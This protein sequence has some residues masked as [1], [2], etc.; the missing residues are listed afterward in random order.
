M[1]KILS[2]FFVLF[3]CAVFADDITPNHTVHVPM[4]D[5]KTLSMDIYLPHEGAENLPCILLRS[6]AGRSA[7]TAKAYAPLA[8]LGYAVAIQDT[9]SA[10]DPE[11]KTLPYVSDSWCRDNDGQ[12]TIAWLSKNPITNGKIGTMGFSAMGITQLLLAPSAPSSLKC[13]FIGTAPASL[14]HYAIFPSGVLLKNQVEG[15]LGYYAR[16]SGVCTFVSNQLFN[17][18]FWEDYDTRLGVDEVKVPAI[19]QGGWYDTFLQ[20]TIE[21]FVTRQESGGEGGRGTQ[22]LLI[23]PWMHFWPMTVKL[24]DFEVPMLGR[25]VPYEISPQRWFDFH[26]K[27]IDNGIGKI[28]AVVYYVM[29]PFDGSESSGNLWRS[30]DKWP[31]PAENISFY[32]GDEGALIEKFNS[33]KE[34]EKVYI[35][36]PSNPIPTI[37]GLNLFLEAGP[38]DQQPIESRSDV[39][40]FTTPVLNEDVEITGRLAAKLFLKSESRDAHVIVKLC[41]VYPDGRSILIAEGVHR[42]GLLPYI[43]GEDITKSEG[44]HEVDVDMWSTAIV[45]AKGHR[46]RISISGSNYPRYENNLNVGAFG[47]HF[48]IWKEAQNRVYYGG[49]YPSH[50]ILPVV[51]KGDKWL[52]QKINEAPMSSKL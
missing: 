15:W 16:D 43:H 46:I 9:R 49:R 42:M 21:A 19:H 12:E 2:I 6:P 44:P 47:T 51:R 23:G 5:G 18:E 8:K 14:Y 11:G 29:G 35:H 7:K 45:F 24:G 39:I 36:D 41:D 30:F 1:R 50:V 48:G 33:A 28:P 26:L 40:T 34:G 13:Q 52:V 31:V 17:N 4:Q 10:L 38:K 22:K 20:G 25:T 32:L 37:G 3:F 27:G